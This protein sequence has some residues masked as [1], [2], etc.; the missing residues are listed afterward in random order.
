MSPAVFLDRDGVVN[1]AIL[2]DGR[3][4]PPAT[5]AELRIEPDAARCVERLHER[6]FRVVVVTN[7]PDV[8]RGTT[9]RAAVETINDAIRAALPVDGL[10]A[11]YHDDADACPCRKPKPGMLVRAAGEL[12]LE[13]SASYM[14]GDRWSDVEAGRRAGCRTVWI[15]RGYLERA[16]ERPDARAATLAQACEWILN[17]RHA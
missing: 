9:T 17:D 16:A 8:A 10:Y 5:L 2:R 15:E 12:G 1:A 14:V 11:C 3:P 6:G 4:H 13:L 7:Q